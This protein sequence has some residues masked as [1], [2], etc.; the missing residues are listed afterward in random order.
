MRNT[1]AQSDIDLLD[2]EP[3]DPE[4]PVED[5]SFSLTFRTEILHRDVTA[6]AALAEEAKVFSPE[7]INLAAELA[8]ERL[9]RGEASGY[10]FLF[11]ETDG[12]LAGY[13]CFGPTPCTRFSY[14]LYWIIVSKNYA[15]RGVGRRLLAR[16]EA[17]IARQGGQRIYI[18]TSSRPTY[19]PARGFYRANGY[20]LEAMIRCFYAPDDHKMLY[21]KIMP[22][23][24]IGC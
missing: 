23:A 7:E 5:L 11:A 9:S 2:R 16:T 20:R 4:S 18:D 12:Q 1:T 19:E 17:T 13:T 15:R 6:I 14:D 3:G 21:L 8:S 10:H 22:A 24:S